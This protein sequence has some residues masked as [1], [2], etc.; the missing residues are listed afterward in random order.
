MSSTRYAKEGSPLRQ[1]RYASD[2]AFNEALKA[3]AV[4]RRCSLFA[5]PA[6]K[7]L[8]LH[9]QYI[10]M[11]PGGLGVFVEDFLTR[12]GDRIGS[13][14][15]RENRTMKAFDAELVRA[16][17]EELLDWRE[18]L[19][20]RDIFPLKGEIETIDPLGFEIEKA[21]RLDAEEGT[22]TFYENRERVR[23]SNIAAGFP[24]E[25]TAAELAEYCL[26]QAKINLEDWLIDFCLNPEADLNNPP[27]WFCELKQSLVDY[28]TDRRDDA[29]A[30]KVV[31]SI[32]EQINDALDYAWDE[33]CMV[34][35]NGVARMG[36]TFQIEQWCRCYPGRVRYVQVPS[37]NDDTSFFR[38]IARSIGTNSGS[39]MNI[40][41]IKRQVE[42]T[43]QD[44][45]IMLVF[46]EAHYLIPA[47]K[48][49]SSYPRRINWVLTEIVNKGIPV[50]IITT[51]QFDVNQ[52]LVVNNTG[53]A[54]EQLDGRIAYRLD[55]PATLPESDL[56][57]IAGHNLPNADKQILFGLCEYA[58]AS[59]KYLAGIEAVAKRAR[60]L[61][62]KSGMTNPN[63]SDIKTAM[64]EV[65]P[66]L[67]KRSQSKEKK[68]D[69]KH[70]AK[71][72][73]RSRR[74]VAE[75]VQTAEKELV[76]AD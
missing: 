65:D 51:P 72:V 76:G 47:Q 53:W 68:P 62:K 9:L 12:Y 41:Q 28:F 73:K 71:A 46:D 18:K 8:C 3:S 69:C 36:K 4:A 67:A 16:I 24:E 39:S 37:S 64:L 59:G 20:A 55:L 6:H 2:P 43:I 58:K 74:G 44:A 14:T 49:G 45:G 63:K 15:M 56:V 34:H 17:R 75:A 13:K 38:A 42:D 23:Q 19:S 7:E 33:K 22:E 54:A 32:G 66:S 52:S 61:A 57:A 48:R 10:S 27:H 1:E 70:P 21:A 50:A 60:F 26:R 35:I 40:T 25:Y 30:G 11:Q 5:D 31:T 29:L